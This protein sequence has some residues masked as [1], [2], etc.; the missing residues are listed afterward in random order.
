M[1][2]SK[3]SEEQVI[4]ILQQADKPDMTVEKVCREHGISEAT[5]YKWKK[6]YRGMAV[7]QV[8]EY[9][10][11]VQ[12]NAKLKQML[13]DTLLEKEAIEAVLKKL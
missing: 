6:Q 11:L 10:K 12:E 4:R 3:Y 13:A 7:N 9:R 5:Y 2:T 1:K 8:K